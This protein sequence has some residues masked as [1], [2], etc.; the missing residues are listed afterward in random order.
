MEEDNI[1][2]H[3]EN[4]VIDSNGK[5]NIL[6]NEL[7]TKTNENY[8]KE[9]EK[10]ENIYRK[11]EEEENIN[12]NE[13][14]TKIAI[15]KTEIESNFSLEK[16]DQNK[17][18]S[19]NLNSLSNKEKALIILFRRNILQYSIQILIPIINKPLFKSLFN[20]LK[21][22]FSLVLSRRKEINEY[23]VD[24]SINHLVSK[25]FNPSKTAINGL[26]FITKDDEIN[27]QN[28]EQ[29]EK[30]INLF[31]LIYI[32][33]NISYTIIPEEKLI[34]HLLKDIFPKLKIDSLSILKY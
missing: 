31:K 22:I 34:E 11:D 28:K 25:Q 7:E 3:N 29:N 27:L 1:T 5:D 15:D 6:N 18:S 24:P 12:K 20:Q 14:I 23:L 17:D 33:L 26:N 30:I 8:E 19:S 4:E 16:L 2:N 10:S 32:F 21:D 13:L 9:H